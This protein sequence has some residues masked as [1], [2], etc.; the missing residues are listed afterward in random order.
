MVK[1]RKRKPT[2]RTDPQRAIE[3]SPVEEIFPSE[4]EMGDAVDAIVRFFNKRYASGSEE[5]GDGRGF[6]IRRLRVVFTKDVQHVE[7]ESDFAQS[8]GTIY[9]PLPSN[10]VENDL[11]ERNDELIRFFAPIIKDSQVRMGLHLYQSLDIQAREKLR[12]KYVG[13]KRPQSSTGS[14]P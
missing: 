10:T 4:E 2:A 3:V 6:T 9:A 7:F 14:K 13:F 11:R 1:D 5:L 8:I 12:E